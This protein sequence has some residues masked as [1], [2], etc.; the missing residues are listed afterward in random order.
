MAA[1]GFCQIRVFSG[2][3]GCGKCYLRKVFTD[4]TMRTTLILLLAGAVTALAEPTAPTPTQ[5]ADAYYAKA[6]AAEKAG[7]VD[8]ARTAYTK[9]LQANPQ[10]ANCRYRLQQ[11]ELNKNAI[12]AKGREGMFNT[13]MIPTV[14]F[15][16][17]TL[18]E[19]F[20]ALN[21]MILKESK[22]KLSPNFVIQDPQNKLANTKISLNLK[23]L[24]ASAVIKYL[25]T[26]G[27]AKARY[28]EHAVVI[29]PK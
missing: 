12:A 24:P 29:E 9:A 5:I 14:Q 6:I 23:N 1:A 7:D 25:L 13:V 18:Q 19:A 8:G 11:L 2:C 21:T 10:H 4:I 3:I 27:G 16:G 17:A 15:D 26:Q 28:D 20:E 22:N